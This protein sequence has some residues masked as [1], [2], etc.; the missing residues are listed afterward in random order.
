MNSITGEMIADPVDVLDR[1]SVHFESV[2]KRNSVVL[3]ETIG[4]ALQ[5]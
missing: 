2:L 3:P 1:W 5:L 4:A